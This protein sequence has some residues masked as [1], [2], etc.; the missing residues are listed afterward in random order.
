MAPTLPPVDTLPNGRAVA[1]LAGEFKKLFGD[2][3][4]TFTTP[5]GANGLALLT[6]EG[7]EISSLKEYADEYRG[8]PIRRKGTATLAELS[9]FIAYIERF[10]DSDSVVFA[11]PNETQPKLV[12][13]LDHHQIGAE[14]HPRF[15]EHR[16]EYCPPL[17]NE[18]AAWKSHEV[19]PMDQGAFAAFLED[20]I[21]DVMLPPL[22]LDN[23]PTLRD[24]IALVGGRF[25]APANLLELSRGLAVSV[26][27]KV[28]NA[29]VLGTGEINVQWEQVHRDGGGQPLTVPN[30]FLL[31]IPVFRAGPV[32]RIPVRL[33]YR[34]SSGK[35]LWSY[36]MYRADKSF[37]H[38]FTEMCVMVKETAGVP[39]FIGTA[40]R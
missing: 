23:E 3:V 8:F 19:S 36:Q 34:I 35:L 21:G 5:D 30:L 6:P 14:G 4:L 2:R 33:R 31:G 27:E 37:D 38:A 1:D 28:K 20:R 22:N 15:G 24:F 32:Y 16:A 12:A 13:V 7:L 18:W 9:S 17:S 39:V 25:A 40:E 11:A 10:K 26:E 29:V